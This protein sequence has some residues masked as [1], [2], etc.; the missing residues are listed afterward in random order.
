VILKAKPLHNRQHGTGG[1]KL[2]KYRVKSLRGLGGVLGEGL[3]ECW[4]EDWEE[5]REE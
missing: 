1:G 4:G 2:G 3:E 5:V